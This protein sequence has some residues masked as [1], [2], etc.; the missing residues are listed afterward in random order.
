MATER[1]KEASKLYGQEIPVHLVKENRPPL[2]QMQQ[3]HKNM[4]DVQRELGVKSVR[5]KMEKIVLE[6]VGHVMGW[7]MIGH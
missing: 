5:Y 4:W 3:E 6:R 2:L 1:D 7:R